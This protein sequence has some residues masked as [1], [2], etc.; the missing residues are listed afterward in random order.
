MW[1][2]DVAAPYYAAGTTG[3][4][5]T[6]RWSEV[7]AAIIMPIGPNPARPSGRPPQPGPLGRIEQILLGW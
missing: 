3:P 5:Y 4:F 1:S 7:G 2:R 6:V